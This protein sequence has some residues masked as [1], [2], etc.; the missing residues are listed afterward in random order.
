MTS[1]V[2]DYERVILFANFYMRVINLV[3]I[4]KFFVCPKWE[5]FLK[6]CWG[7][8][9]GTLCIVWGLEGVVQWMHLQVMQCVLV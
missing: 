8:Y 1:L 5:L 9:L 2:L 7:S 4:S 3:S 6:L